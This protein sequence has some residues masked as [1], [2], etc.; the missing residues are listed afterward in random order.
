ML[1]VSFSLSNFAEW[2]PITTSS[3]GYF[4]SSFSRSGRTWMQLMQ[5]R[6]QKSRITILPR[7][8]FSLIG[9]A[10]FSQATPP[11]SSG[12]ST[13]CARV[14][15]RLRR[16]WKPTGRASATGPSAW[17]RNTTATAVG[18]PS[19]RNRKSQRTNRLLPGAPAFVPGDS[20]GVID[21]LLRR[22]QRDF[23]EGRRGLLPDRCLRGIVSYPGPAYPGAISAG[24]HVSTCWT[25][26]VTC[27]FTPWLIDPAG[28]Y[29]LP[30]TAERAAPNHPARTLRRGT[31]HGQR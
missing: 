24:R 26:P 10:V 28:G 22:G 13:R 2:T 4:F 29:T 16:S 27:R 5:H 11:S 15:P 17:T 9:P 1:S 12:A 25:L 23:G 31:R 6:V 18:I 21:G 3:L 7:R 19:P 14:P 8:S 30:W 20:G